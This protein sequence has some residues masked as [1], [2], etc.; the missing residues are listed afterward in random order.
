[1]LTCPHSFGNE[2][3]LE[4][5]GWL[6]ATAFANQSYREVK[7]DSNGTS[8]GEAKTVG[9]MTWLKVYEA[10]HVS[11]EASIC[12]GTKLT[13]GMASAGGPRL[14]ASSCLRNLRQDDEGRNTLRQYHKRNKSELKWV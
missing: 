5:P 12:C 11:V 8:Y 10:G 3:C 9:N 13:Q 1:M 4:D 14:Q 6:G 7:Y 2:K